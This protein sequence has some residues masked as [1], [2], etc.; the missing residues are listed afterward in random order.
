ML[1]DEIPGKLPEKPGEKHEKLP[2]LGRKYGK[3]K[4]K[5]GN[6]CFLMSF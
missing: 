4:G 2:A 3:L 6:H 5:L 1:K